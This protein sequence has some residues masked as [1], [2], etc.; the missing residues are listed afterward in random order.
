MTTATSTDNLDVARIGR[1]AAP[2]PARV[3]AEPETG[4]ASL[5]AAVRRTADRRAA[6]V[7]R[8]RRLRFVLMIPISVAAVFALVALTSIMI[9]YVGQQ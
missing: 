8:G 1:S 3:P 6:Q 2:V 4:S 5:Q 9:T 7:A